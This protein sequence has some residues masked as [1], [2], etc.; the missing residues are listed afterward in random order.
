MED[1]QLC[2]YEWSGGNFYFGISYFEN[3]VNP[4]HGNTTTKRRFKI[5]NCVKPIASMDSTGFVKVVAPF[6]SGCLKLNSGNIQS[7][8]DP[9]YKIYELADSL[10]E[11][12]LQEKNV[13]LLGNKDVTMKYIRMAINR[14]IDG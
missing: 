3:C 10:L 13:L 4:G 14:Y 8:P 2:I 12:D 5:I 9:G 11:R 7:D 1:E 6:D